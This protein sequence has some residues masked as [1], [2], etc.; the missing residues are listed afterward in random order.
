MTRA[1][2]ILM[3]MFVAGGL[4]GSAL[5]GAA[6]WAESSALKPFFGTYVGAS[7]M[8]SAE[9]LPRDLR[10][11]IE[12]ADGDGFIIQWQTTLFKYRE[13]QR[14]KTQL[15]QFRPTKNDPSLYQAVPSDV[16]AG[17]EPSETPLDGGPLAWAHVQGRMMNIHILTI[18]ENGGYV[19]QSYDREL[20]NGG[21]KL[22]FTRVRN[23]TV[24]QRLLAE[25]ARIDG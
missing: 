17:M 10:V 19:M 21:M 18:V 25:L 12:P 22:S 6:A 3:C 1:L 23:G 9:M 13:A 20:T 24:E 5:G 4:A 15:L 7:L 14:R 11:S 16:T 2:R 8:P